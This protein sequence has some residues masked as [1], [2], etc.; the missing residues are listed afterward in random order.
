MRESLPSECNACITNPRQATE[1]ARISPDKRA[2][3]I[4]IAAETAKDSLRGFD[5]RRGLSTL[6]PRSKR[7]AHAGLEGKFSGNLTD[8]DREKRPME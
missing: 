7:P 8:S 5:A 4:E 1:L 2:Q 3:V 6:G